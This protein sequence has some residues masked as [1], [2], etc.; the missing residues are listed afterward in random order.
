MSENI[1][2]FTPVGGDV[3]RIERQL[4]AAGLGGGRGRF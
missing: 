1:A 2:R 3:K 4:E